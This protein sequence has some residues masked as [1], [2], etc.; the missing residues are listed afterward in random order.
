MPLW[1]LDP[2]RHW[3][4]RLWGS[5]VYGRDEGGGEDW[6]GVRVMW[7]CQGVWAKEIRF[8]DVLGIFGCLKGRALDEAGF[9]IVGFCPD[10]W[11]QRFQAT[12]E[13]PQIMFIKFHWHRSFFAR[14]PPRSLFQRY[15]GERVTSRARIYEVPFDSPYGRAGC[16][17]AWRSVCILRMAMARPCPRMIDKQH[18]KETSI[19]HI[20]ETVACN[21]CTSLH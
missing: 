5:T 19:L 16:G 13:P 17:G 1:A 15:Q 20:W 7:E 12:R 3:A 10:L 6:G 4:P 2:L 9:A 18:Q 11:T 14:S 21:R 8:W